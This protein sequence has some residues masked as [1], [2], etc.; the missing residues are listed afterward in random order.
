MQAKLLLCQRVST[1]FFFSLKIAIKLTQKK[2]NDNSCIHTRKTENDVLMNSARNH[3][4]FRYQKYISHVWNIYFYGYKSTKL[5]LVSNN[6][7]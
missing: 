3:T 4:N 5:F 6:F 7:Y 2:K 1:T